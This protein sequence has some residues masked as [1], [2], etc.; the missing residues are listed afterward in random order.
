MKYI[1]YLNDKIYF[2]RK[3]EKK[4]SSEYFIVNSNNV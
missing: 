4:D 2:K 1:L 3:V